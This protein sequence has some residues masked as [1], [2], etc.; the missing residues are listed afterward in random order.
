[1]VRLPTLKMEIVVTIIIVIM[2]ANTYSANYNLAVFPI[3]GY[4]LKMS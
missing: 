1:M 2:I 4:S 3:Y